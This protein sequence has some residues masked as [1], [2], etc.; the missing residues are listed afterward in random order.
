MLP[1]TW[2]QT[3]ESAVPEPAVG[4]PTSEDRAARVRAGVGNQ[5]IVRRRAV[6]QQGAKGA[7]EDP[8]VAAGE[9]R[10]SADVTVANE[11]TATAVPAGRQ[12]Q[13]PILG[14][15]QYLTFDD[16]G[17]RFYLFRLEDAIMLGPRLKRATLLRYFADNFDLSSVKD[18]EAFVDE[19]AGRE[20]VA[21]VPQGGATAPPATKPGASKEQLLHAVEVPA[22]LHARALLWIRLRHP[23]IAPRH[24]EE[25]VGI[26]A[27]TGEEK[28]GRGGFQERRF[29]PRGEIRLN[30]RPVRSEDE[31]PT[32][33]AYGDLTSTSTVTAS[34]HFEESDP[35]R[36][37]LNFFPNH[38]DFDW[39]LTRGGKVVDT[40]PI[41]KYGEISR[42]LKLPDPGLYTLTVTVKSPYF[43]SGRRLEL[44]TYLWALKE[45]Q[46][47][48]DVFEQYLVGDD[49][50]QPFVRAPDGTLKIKEGRPVKTIEDEILE[51]NAMIGAIKRL[52]KD[53]KLDSDDAE[54]QLKYLGEKLT[55]L[56]KVQGV[57][58]TDQAACTTSR[59]P[60]LTPSATSANRRRSLVR[61]TPSRRKPASR[62]RRCSR[63]PT[64]GTPTTTTA[65]GPSSSPSACSRLP[66]S[67]TRSRS[68]RTTS[69]GPARRS[70][71][72]LPQS[73]G[74]SCSAW[75]RSPAARP[76]PWV[77][78]FSRA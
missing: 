72:A 37:M 74:L 24:L 50:E 33:V 4:A 55:S 26:K 22:E 65:T 18:R 20:G 39:K 75:P 57:V 60:P 68:T 70:A 25:K 78:S 19:F 2:E 49:P 66:A 14:P 10:T 5:A 45:A 15:D 31:I 41:I 11:S 29:E 34:V 58:G 21:Y 8:E 69:C 7:E 67:S 46:R 76:R 16:K 1:P 27:R 56:E 73:A 23:E 62:S 63:W 44:E 77:C 36:N 13:V 12:T 61:R 40:G 38:A 71:P 6:L 17:S 32:Y 54:V 30:P 28:A 43:T 9:E 53:G 35:D 51:L 3:L 42:K 64:T 59:C 47:A 48:A 52:E